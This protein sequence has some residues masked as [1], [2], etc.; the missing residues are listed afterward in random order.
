[1]ILILCKIKNVFPYFFIIETNLFSRTF[2]P[3]LRPRLN[4]VHKHKISGLLLTFVVMNDTQEG[5]Q[6]LFSF[7]MCFKF[8]V[9]T[10]LAFFCQPG[11]VIRLI[12]FLIM[13]NFW[14]KLMKN[15]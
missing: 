13:W 7:N 10:C 9:N 5:T 12:Y 14:N 8:N 3:A 2:S 11:Q 6:I 4:C 1:M 15:E